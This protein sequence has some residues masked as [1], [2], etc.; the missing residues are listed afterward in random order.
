MDGLIALALAKKEINSRD[1][2]FNS[3]DRLDTYLYKISFNELAPYKERNIVPYGCST[4]ILDGKMYRN[5]DWKYDETPEFYVKCKNFEG[6]AINFNITDDWI[7]NYE[8]LDQLPYCIVDGINDNGIMV[9]THILYNDF[10]WTQSGDGSNPITMMPY[11]I[12]NEVKSMDT[13]EQDLDPYICNMKGIEGSD[14]LVQ[15]MISDGATTYVLIPPEESDGD[16]ELVDASENPKLTNFRWMS[17]NKVDLSD[18]G[19][20]ERPTGLE[21]FNAMDFEDWYIG[22][23]N[24]EGI[25]FTNAY[26]DADT[27]TDFIGINETTKHS[28]EEELYAIKEAASDLYQIRERNGETWQTVHNSVYSPD[29]GGLIKLFVQ[30]NWRRNY[31]PY[32]YVPPER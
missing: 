6:M 18:E 23:D 25:K 32:Q 12:L 17:K 4:V 13:I 26:T 8:D 7:M 28:T 2:H 20:Q 11:L 10:G 29:G 5:F 16:Y 19:L 21:R 27:I 31:A 14:Y 24:L 22:Y 30:E 1:H 3:L 15:F 9:S